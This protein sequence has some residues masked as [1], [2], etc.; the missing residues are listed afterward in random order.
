[1]NDSFVPSLLLLLVLSSA[2]VCALERGSR[3]RQFVHALELFDDAKSSEDYLEAARV[4]ETLLVDGYRNGA[5]YYNLGNAYYRAGE[6]GRAILNY[7]KAIPFR[8]RDPYLAA[9]LQQA[10]IAAPGR[11]S[12]PPRAWWTHVLFWTEWLSFPSKVKLVF[13]GL[14]LAA[15][16]TTLAV[17]FRMPRVVLPITILMV[18][19]LAI[20]ID[21]VL[22][23]SEIMGS[24]LAVIT[25]ETIARK[26]T[27]QS[28][29][30]AFDQ[31]LRDGAEFEML[32]ETP[33]WTFGHFEGIGDGWIR[34]EFVAK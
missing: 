34:N 9:N 32:S 29:E 12:E 3:E 25:G 13:G 16:A 10:L 14:T 8:P 1:M 26:G 22:C 20:G 19:T 33:E 7:R 17:W 6:Y 11:L 21:A 15:I 30:P 5:V 18:C 28:Y 2:E 31:P 23:D 27:G 24:K 4:L